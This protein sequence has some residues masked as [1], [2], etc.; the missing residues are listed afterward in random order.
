MRHQRPDR[1][2][3]RRHRIVGERIEARRRRLRQPVARRELAHA[4]ARDHELHQAARDGGA[5]DDAGAQAEV[6]G[7]QGAGLGQREQAVEH[8][9]DAVQRGAGLGEEG[10]EGGGG[11]KGLGGVDDL[12]AVRE[13]GHEAEDEAEAVEEG[14]GAAE[15]VGMGEAEAVADEARVVD[16]VVV[17]EH[18]GF[19][20]AGGAAGELEVAD[21]VGEDFGGDVVEAVRVGFGAA[22]E[23]LLVGGVVAGGA[24]EDDDGELALGVEGE[25]GEEGAVVQTADC[26]GGEEDFAVWE[27]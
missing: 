13:D 11:V 4:Q 19:G 27:S 2:Q 24:A 1:P 18:G 25:A 3:P 9:G 17:G 21:E 23:D 7:A 10:T 20:E 15:G 5:G 26:L 6:G 22:G 14:G 16:D 12:G 8:G